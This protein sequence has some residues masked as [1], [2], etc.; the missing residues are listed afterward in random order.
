[1]YVAPFA[2]AATSRRILMQA[3]PLSGV[4]AAQSYSIQLEFLARGARFG[5][6]IID[7]VAA[8][9]QEEAPDLLH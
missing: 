1:M 4:F 3:A 6:R 7:A 5:A 8:L 9:T 2:G